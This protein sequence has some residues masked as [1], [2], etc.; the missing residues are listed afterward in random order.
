VGAT[1]SS[2]YTC[3]S[4]PDSQKISIEQRI[5]E[6]CKAWIALDNENRKGNALEDSRIGAFHREEIGGLGDNGI[7]PYNALYSTFAAST[8]VEHAGQWA[9]VGLRRI[10]NTKVGG[11]PTYNYEPGDLPTSLADFGIPGIP[12]LVERIC[13]VE[14]AEFQLFMD[15]TTDTD[16]ESNRKAFLDYPAAPDGTPPPSGEGGDSSGMVPVDPKKAEDLLGKRPEIL[17]HTQDN[18]IIGKNTGSLGVTANGDTIASG[19]FETTGAIK[20]YPG[21]KLGA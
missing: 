14:L 20:K 19:Q 5:A 18:W 21:P 2:L 17:L 11:M 6:P 4:N 10:Q 7:A 16:N 15:V 12:A 3:S 9:G 8:G 13:N 1:A